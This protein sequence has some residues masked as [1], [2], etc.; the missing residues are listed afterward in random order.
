MD[1][2]IIRDHATS[3]SRGFGFII[4]DSEQ[5]VD[6]LLADSNMID[7]AGAQVSREQ[8]LPPNISADT[9]FGLCHFT[10]NTIDF[11]RWYTS[12]V[13]LLK[14]FCNMLSFHF[15]T[16][17]ITIMGST[18]LCGFCLLLRQRSLQIYR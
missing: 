14:F 5:V 16:H 2:Q 15:F 18:S 13:S 9:D 17:Y 8:C 10:N 7:L 1:S 11:F 3:R 6:D 4:F 12:S